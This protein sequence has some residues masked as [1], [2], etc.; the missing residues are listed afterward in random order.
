MCRRSLVGSALLT[1]VALSSLQF[2]LAAGPSARKVLG[3]RDLVLLRTLIQSVDATEP[4]VASDSNL[5]WDIHVLKSGNLAG[6]VPFTIALSGE[7]AAFKSV[8]MYVRATLRHDGP[9]VEE[10]SIFRDWLTNTSVSTSVIT[11]L[12]GLLPE[13]MPMGGPA[14]RLGDKRRQRLHQSSSLLALQVKAIARERSAASNL[15]AFEDYHFFDTKPGRADEPRVVQRALALPRGEYDVSVALLDPARMKPGGSAT[16]LS[17]TVFVPDYRVDGLELSSLILVNSLRTLAAPYTFEQ[18]IEHPYAFGGT[19]IVPAMSSTFAASD[20]LSV[21]FQICNF[22]A[23]ESRL[24]IAYDFYRTV[25]GKRRRFNRTAPYELTD[26]DLSQSPSSPAS[27]TLAYVMQSM[28][29]ASFQPGRY[30]LEV[31]VKDHVT[32]LTRKAAVAF[33]VVTPTGGT[34]VMDRTPPQS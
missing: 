10:H 34:R 8:A 26:T 19:E 25:D 21:T 14:V 30:E 6:Y 29:L 1:V 3:P 4:G 11:D 18:Q 17:R 32:L 13:E 27:N 28:P 31:T 24:T 12:L 7:P 23:P 5:T 2:V 20:L 15:Y 22:G 9:P 16:V 33:T